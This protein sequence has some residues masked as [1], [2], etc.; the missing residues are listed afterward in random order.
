M[1]AAAEVGAK[2]GEEVE[3]ERENTPAPP[4][5]IFEAPPPI[6]LS[7]SKH[8]R[9]HTEPPLF[10]PLSFFQIFRHHFNLPF[11]KVACGF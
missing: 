2:K 9:T 10:S 4:L 3:R 11:K 7:H 5:W 6:F 8:T 1:A